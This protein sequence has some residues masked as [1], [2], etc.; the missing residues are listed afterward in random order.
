VLEEVPI[1]LRIELLKTTAACLKV[2]NACSG[3]GQACYHL[4]SEDE[5]WA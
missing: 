2:E 1:S 5:A 3:E 4:G